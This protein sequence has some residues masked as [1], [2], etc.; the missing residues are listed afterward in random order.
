MSSSL[1]QSIAV[2][3]LSG[4]VLAAC[5]SRPKR[6][7]NDQAQPPPADTP[8][9]PVAE[10]GSEAPAPV[11]TPAPGTPATNVAAVSEDDAARVDERLFGLWIPDSSG[12]VWQEPGEL[13]PST[14]SLTTYIG[15]DSF[16]TTARCTFG[17]GAVLEARAESKATVTAATIRIERTVEA[18][19]T[20]ETVE[21][22]AT[23]TCTARVESGTIHYD[24]ESDFELE[25]RF[26]GGTIA[27]FV[28]Q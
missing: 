3:L 18:I 12:L 17:D 19:D 8:A 2:L 10:G 15:G 4:A 28:K 6:A 5:G 22:G 27:T 20:D 1:P 9:V 11:S 26:E 16:E 14:M 24:L 13:F 25:L 7:Q 23:H 21:T